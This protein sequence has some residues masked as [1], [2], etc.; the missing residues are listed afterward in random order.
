MVNSGWRLQLVCGERGFVAR[1]PGRL[2]QVESQGKSL[3]A[4]LIQYLT[5]GYWRASERG[6]EHCDENLLSK[7][8]SFIFLCGLESSLLK[9]HS[10]VCKSLK[11]REL[12]NKPTLCQTLLFICSV[13]TERTSILLISG[14]LQTRTFSVT[15]PESY[16]L[17]PGI[18]YASQSGEIMEL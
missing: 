16:N 9:T 4:E 8:D 12:G 1:K 10:H 2:A 14:V 15:C 5:K 18:R 3:T 11:G 17:P 6:C 13:Q 7:L